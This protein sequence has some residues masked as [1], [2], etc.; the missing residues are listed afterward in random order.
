MSTNGLG[1][2]GKYVGWREANVVYGHARPEIVQMFK[3]FWK[4]SKKIDEADLEAASVAWAKRQHMNAIVTARQ[5]GLSLVDI[6]RTAPAELDALNVRM[7]VYDTVTD[8]DDL[9][10]LDNAEREVR[11]QYGQAF[12]VYWD[13]DSITTDASTAYLVDY[14]WPARGGIARGML[15]RRNA[16][17]FPDFEQDGETF[18]VAYEI[19]DIEG[20]TFGAVDRAIIGRA[21]HAYVK[22]GA[23]GEEKGQRIYNF[24]ISELAPYLTATE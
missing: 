3:A 6:L 10:V 24:P 18:H 22:A 23:A 16:G 17:D 21:F 12:Q 4:A 13:W 14:D 8:P 5:G 20:I 2:E 7:V 15:Y 1:T 9:A 19:D 11:D